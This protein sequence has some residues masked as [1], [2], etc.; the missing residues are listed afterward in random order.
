MPINPLAIF[1]RCFCPPDKFDALFCNTKFIV[2]SFLLTNSLELD[3]SKLLI[4]SFSSE[5]LPKKIFSKIVA[6]IKSGFCPIYVILDFKNLELYSFIS[7]PYN[8]KVPEV[9]VID[10]FNNFK[11]V[12]LPEPVSPIIPIISPGFT[13]KAMSFKFILEKY[14]KFIADISKT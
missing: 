10:L 7:F 4:I 5:V 14:E 1:I 2:L 3:N 9:L 6:V 8:F 13:C 11:K 12:V